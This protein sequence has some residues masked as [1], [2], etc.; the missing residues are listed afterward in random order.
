M[1]T[2]TGPEITSPPERDPNAPQ[3]RRDF[4]IEMDGPPMWVALIFFGL[5]VLWLWERVQQG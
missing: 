1:G 4:F 2:E 3:L 5:I